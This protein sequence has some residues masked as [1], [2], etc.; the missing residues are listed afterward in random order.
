MKGVGIL[1]DG[2]DRDPVKEQE[3]GEN[4]GHD[5]PVR[6]CPGAKAELCGITPAKSP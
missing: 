4:K 1:W 2:A 3:G 6:L 5:G